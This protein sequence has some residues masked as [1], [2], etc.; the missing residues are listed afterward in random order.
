[1]RKNFPSQ[2][3]SFKKKKLSWYF[4]SCRNVFKRNRSLAQAK[5]IGTRAWKHYKFSP[6]G[7]Q[8]PLTRFFTMLSLCIQQTHCFSWKKKP[9]SADLVRRRKRRAAAVEGAAPLLRPPAR[10]GAAPPPAPRCL[11]SPGGRA[12]VYTYICTYIWIYT[13]IDV[14]I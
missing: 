5:R 6:T 4:S 12:P 8:L 9:R 14:C 2:L 11:L 3:Q 13:R 10:G 1:M 7:I